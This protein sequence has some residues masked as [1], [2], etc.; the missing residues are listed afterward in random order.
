MPDPTASDRFV[1][2]GSDR[3]RLLPT[4]CAEDG[5][6]AETPI[7]ER[8]F[9]DEE[10]REILK[11]AVRTVP[12]HAVT[13]GEGL[14]LGE[15][16]AIG[17]EVGIDPVRLEDAARD[18]V[19]GRSGRSSLL[20][21]A[22]T[23]M[24]FERKVEG[25][26]DPKDTPEIL[27][28]IRRTMGRQGEAGEIHGSL[29]WRAEGDAGARWITLSTR[30]GVTT[31]RGSANLNSAA[32]LTFMPAGILGLFTSLIGLVQFAQDGSP[33]SLVLFLAVLPILYPILRSILR[34]VADLESAK[35]RRVV[36]ELARLVD[37]SD[38]G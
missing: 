30:D 27:S 11:R 33:E 20:L 17:E 32:V 19:S 7:D 2:R 1:F 12:S 15:L 10:V 37:G 31:I 13:R 36:D 16:K 5:I 21:G 18:V 25:A 14:S 23:V 26:F 29:E 34:R 35:L 22:P 4:R 24:V 9:T 6:V 3:A 38:A 28:V 8:R